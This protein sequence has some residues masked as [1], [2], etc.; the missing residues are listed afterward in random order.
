VGKANL[1]SN[2]ENFKCPL[3]GKPLESDEY[4]SAIK[5]LE[6]QVAER[7]NE[8]NQQSK[9]EFEREIKKLT[10]AHQ[11]EVKNLKNSYEEQQRAFR[12]ELQNSNKKQLAGF[13]KSYD[14]LARKNQKAFGSL[15]KTLEDEHKKEL[16]KKDQQL[17]EMRKEQSRLRKL[18]YEEAKDEDSAEIRKLKGDIGERD[19]QIRRFT[20]E[21]EELKRQ[22]SESQAELKG[23]AGEIDLYSTL[24]QA[25]PED[26]IRRQKRGEVS[27][28][29][30]QHIRTLSKTLATPIVYDNK[31]AERVTKK[32]IEKAKNYKK[33]HS[34]EYVIIV[35]SNLPKKDIKNGLCG[36]K[37]GILLAHPSI[38]IDFSRQIRKAII[39]ISKQSESEKDRETKESKLYDYVKSQDFGNTIE[40]IYGIHQKM[41]ELQNREEKAHERLWKERKELQS[42]INQTYMKISSGIE[43]IIQEKPPMEELTKEDTEEKGI[44]EPAKEQLPVLEVKRKKKKATQTESS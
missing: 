12:K 4:Q 1:T 31:Q 22:L 30:V 10:E 34:T 28:D 27:G 13:K 20:G 37:D 42:Q 18:A 21:V 6:G 5:K 8:K 2:L 23:E 39:E 17:T 44:E 15:K 35:S 33:V 9:Q 32:D 3:C 41:T 36:E 40:K 26:N 25:F 38:V 16:R 24:V 43:T 7:Y 11:A 14:E 29:L 19:I